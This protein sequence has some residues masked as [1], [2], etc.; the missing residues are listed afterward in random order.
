MRTKPKHIEDALLQAER[1]LEDRGS[2]A[3]Q[4]A[5]ETLKQPWEKN[6]NQTS[7]PWTIQCFHGTAYVDYYMHRHDFHDVVLSYE[8]DTK[9]MV[10]ADTDLSRNNRKRHSV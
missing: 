8:Y 4:K 6:M 9:A 10:F 1:H 3:I 7:R 5:T 2:R